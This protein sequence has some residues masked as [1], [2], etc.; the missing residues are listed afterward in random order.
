MA[1][2]EYNEAVKAAQAAYDADI[3][4]Y[5]APIDDTGFSALTAEI[6][7]Q[8][9]TSQRPNC[10]L[11][12]TTNG[13]LANSAYQI[14][15]ILQST[16]SEFALYTPRYCK[17]AGTVIALGAHRIIMDVFSELGPLDVQLLNK[18]EIGNRKS[19]LLSRAAFDSLSD[20]A[21]QMFS[22]NM[23]GIK[24]SSGGLISFKLAADISWRLTA[25]LM[26]PIFAQINPDVIGSD[27]RD[28]S[29]AT[30]YGER[31]A[32]ISLN[33][34]ARAVHKL[35]ADYPSHDFIIDREEAATLFNKVDE[36]KSELYALVGLISDIAYQQAMPGVVTGCTEIPQEDTGEDEGN[37]T[38]EPAAEDQAAAMDNGGRRNRRR[39]QGQGNAATPE[40]Q[41][42]E[43]AQAQEGQ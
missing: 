29:I 6:A 40:D 28:L 20:E 33:P 37:E 1:F 5:S 9:A 7:K 21:F 22:K 8:R 43:P 30:S 18:D 41:P 12:L 10:L 36:P 26:S 13:G 19:G 42:A 2:E 38:A 3:Y 27:H 4:L 34:K 32:K 15:R 16:Y 14:A 23:M 39:N 25:E 35:V 31:L 17:S 24:T 11:I